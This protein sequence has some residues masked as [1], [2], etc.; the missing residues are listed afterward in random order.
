M[1]IR[2]DATVDAADEEIAGLQ[3]LIRA[4]QTRR[5]E[6][7]S[8]N[9]L[10]R[11]TLVEVFRY[12]LD[13]SS[14]YKSLPFM[15]VCTLWR[16]IASECPS[17]WSDLELWPLPRFNM[18]LA[19]AKEALLTVKAS[20]STAHVENTSIL[21]G[22]CFSGGK[23]R[24]RTQKLTEGIATLRDLVASPKQLHS[25]ILTGEL[26]HC[27]SVVADIRLPRPEL[28][29]L[30]IHVSEIPTGQ[31]AQAEPTYSF[32]L[33]C[34][35]SLRTLELTNIL[36]SWHHAIHRSLVKLDVR[37]CYPR[38]HWTTLR[39]ALAQARSLRTIKLIDCLSNELGG[40]ADG[41]NTVPF[42]RAGL[43]HLVD[44][45]LHGL[46]VRVA[47]QWFA[48]FHI[49]ARCS[50]YLQTVDE[51]GDEENEGD[52]N[53]LLSQ[54]CRS[55]GARISEFADEGDLCSIMLFHTELSGSIQAIAESDCETKLGAFTFRVL[56]NIPSGN[57][58]H[59]LRALSTEMASKQIHAFK[60]DSHV[61]VSA[62]TWLAICKALSRLT[63]LGIYGWP[64]VGLLRLLAARR[65]PKTPILLRHLQTLVVTDMNLKRAQRAQRTKDPQVSYTELYEALHARSAIY[66]IQELHL[67][68]CYYVTDATI[69]GLKKEVEHLK[70]DE[71]D[72]DKKSTLRRPPTDGEVMEN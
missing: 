42:T 8:I 22:R 13:G 5:N 31:T 17:L 65:K 4:R 30:S 3:A 68:S 47:C 32:P 15:L 9:R 57:H 7:I 55:I 50:V 56:L 69:E 44:V 61:H 36:V 16:E 59:L 40:D 43:P 1:S 20:L 38:V 52:G 63:Y 10:P 33:G 53:M 18:F 49:P 14:K 23:H 27:H 62:S 51:P 71:D 58:T 46:S 60:L 28:Q 6:L 54:L 12:A 11:E 2:S 25:L 66:P 39:P 48:D 45:T 21:R 26:E 37:S 35:P 72:M 64:G 29:F 34:M 67:N 19:L 24:R 41:P 70:F